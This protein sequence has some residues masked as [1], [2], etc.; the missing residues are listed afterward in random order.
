LKTASS[1]RVCSVVAVEN[2]SDEKNRM[3]KKAG[4]NGMPL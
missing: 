2:K 1:H 4:K 3:H